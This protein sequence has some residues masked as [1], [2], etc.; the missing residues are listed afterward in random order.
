MHKHKV[1]IDISH[2]SE[3][4]IEATFDLVESLDAD[5]GADKLDFPLI[6]THVGMRSEGPDAQAYN[7]S[8][9]TAKRIRERG[10]LI[11]LIMAQHQL[12]KTADATASRAVVNRHLQA[13]EQACGD[14]QATAF[15]TDLDG[16]IKPTI[17]GVQRAADLSVLAEWIRE[18]HPGDAQDILYGNARR[19]FKRVFEAR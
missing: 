9:A 18:D 16:F 6:A 19:V 3:E 15:G 5:S 10:G 12:G 4:A 14:H 2:M 7:L 8:Q 17:E 13:I 11:G 1:L